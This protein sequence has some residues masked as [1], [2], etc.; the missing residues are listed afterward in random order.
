MRV[1]SL[2]SPREESASGAE[3]IV[4]REKRRPSA[5]DPHSSR[6]SPSIRNDQSR[7]IS[8]VPTSAPKRTTNHLGITPSNRRQKPG[9]M[10]EKVHATKTLARQNFI[11]LGRRV[12]LDLDVLRRR[13]RRFRRRCGDAV[14]MTDSGRSRDPLSHAQSLPPS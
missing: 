14:G 6:T 1:K 10:I 2:R 4:G 5:A 13:W 11:A 12:L 3:R 8:A 7:D 9:K